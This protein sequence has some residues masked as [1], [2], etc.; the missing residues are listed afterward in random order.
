[1]LGGARLLLLDRPKTRRIA[2]QSVRFVAGSS[3]SPAKADRILSDLG[4]GASDDCGGNVMINSVRQLPNYYETLGL[5]PAATDEEIGQAFA[6]KMSECRWDP[7]GPSARICI[8]YETLSNRFKR[9]DYDRSHGLEPTPR[10]RLS[11]MAVTQ[12]RWAPFIASMPTNALGQAASETSAMPQVTE[13]DAPEVLAGSKPSSFIA[14]SLRELARPA[15]PG[16]SAEALAQRRERPR[17]EANPEAQIQQMLATRLPERASRRQFEDRQFDWK[18]PTLAVVGCLVAAGFIG[19]FA[20]LSLKDDESSA[21]AEQP[22]MVAPTV[23]QHSEAAATS[24]P[25]LAGEASTNTDWMA[26][27]A[28]A[29]LRTRPTHSWYAHSW[30]GHS[31]RAH[32]RGGRR[33]VETLAAESDPASAPPSTGVTNQIATKVSVAQPVGPEGPSPQ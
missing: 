23:R 13:R 16:S 31:W 26:R 10:P 12:Q 28:R 11:A 22:A 18:R 9:A 30:H 21:H 14:A 17:P 25:S 15:R 8:A 5:T 3:W 24:T 29:E 7:M 33:S 1:M 32:S 27:P 4:L 6:R 2:D 20:G 19:A